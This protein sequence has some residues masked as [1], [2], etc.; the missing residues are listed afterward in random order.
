MVLS[1][2]WRKLIGGYDAAKMIAET[3]KSG[4]KNSEEITKGMYAIKS[5]EGAS[6]NITIND[7]GSA[8]KFVELF[9]PVIK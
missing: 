4:A 3:I 6:G 1:W 8:P 9:R 2:Q 7:K 5:Y